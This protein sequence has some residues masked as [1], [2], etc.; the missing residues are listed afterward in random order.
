VWI[1]FAVYALLYHSIRVKNTTI[2][3]SGLFLQDQVH[4]SH[5]VSPTR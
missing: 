3:E 2:T 1:T 5:N 4:S